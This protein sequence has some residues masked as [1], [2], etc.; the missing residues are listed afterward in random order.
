MV[1]RPPAT[2][3][4]APGCLCRFFR[5]VQ[6]DPSVT[7]GK[8]GVPPLPAQPDPQ[9]CE[10]YPDGPVTDAAQEDAVNEI[11]ESCDACRSDDPAHALTGRLCARH[12]RERLRTIRLGSLGR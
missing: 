5:A 3:C 2:R 12:R 6:D 7:H 9:G 8:H 4:D 1:D 11:W 10:D